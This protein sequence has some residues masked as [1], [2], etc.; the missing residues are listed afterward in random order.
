VTD[1]PEKTPQRSHTAKRGAPGAGTSGAA[2]A[3][4]PAPA[5]AADNGH[6]RKWLIL[7]AVSLGMFMALLDVT[8]VNI[9]IPAIMEDLDATI[10]KVS[11]V[12]NAYNLAMAALFL[13]MGRIADKFGQKLVFVSGV[14]VF[15]L[16]SLLCGLSPTIDW[17]IAFR[18][19][20][21]VGGAMMMPISLSILM[22]AFPKRQHGT[23]VG[24]WGALG[25]AAAALGP[26]IGGL[27][28]TY[29]SWHWI[30]FINVPIGIAALVFALVVVPERRRADAKAGVDIGGILI[31]T[32]GLFCLVLALTQ[33]N[34]WGWTSWRILLLFAVALI[35]YPV[36]YVWETRV[37][38]SPMFDFRLLRIR[39]FTA[40]NTAIMAMG[41]AMGGAFL[42][43]VIF[44]VN[45]MGYSELRAA[46][47]MTFMPF[48]ALF[49]APLT[50]RQ[51]DRIGPRIP[52]AVGLA[53][54]GTGML[55]LTQLDAYSSIGDVAWRLGIMGFGMG[56]SMPAIAAA[57]MGSL[58]PQFGGVGAGAFSTLRQIGLVLGV[59][60]SVSI[61][62]HTVAIE[63]QTA[64]T[65]AVTYVAAQG[66]IQP[67]AKIRI[68]DGLKKTAATAAAGGSEAGQ[69]LGGD[70][71]AM[72]APPAGTP[73]EQV[74]QIEAQQKSLQERIAGFFKTQVA[75]AFAW[76][77][78]A[79]AIA[80]FLGVVPA[81][82]TGRRLGEHEGHHEMDRG[83]RAA[84]MA[85]H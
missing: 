79:A 36:F 59:A 64:A 70:Q 2:R 65:K 43:L 23:A 22:G 17:L 8:I 29:A 57:A 74:A 72:P 18:V 50:G 6:P 24:I 10:T 55:L 5:D 40:A 60:I 76:P 49:V 84:A 75:D 54:F 11:W 19:G 69:R 35:C 81:L 83:E 34:D 13:S 27:L 7:A 85:G 16:F 71:A 28:V 20:Q 47:A 63:V 56:L 41:A 37:V 48:T 12:L 62:T 1:E 15:T 68:I 82:M 66:Q 14:A 3:A 9:A 33:G 4:S 77:F 38:S 46:L 42:L 73:P 78:F 58:P 30:F 67:Q 25:T 61:F 39:S 53:L 21:G 45:V 26:S 31:S 32:G 44:M 80:A 52:A 51:V